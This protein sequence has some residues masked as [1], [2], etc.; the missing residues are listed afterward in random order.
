MN[1]QKVLNE[2]SN[3]HL[4][5]ITFPS[6]AATEV[7][8]PVLIEAG[9]RKILVDCGYPG[10]APL[11]EEALVQA[12]TNLNEVTDI[13]ITHH[14]LD[15]VGALYEIVQAHPRIQV[16]AS[17][18]ESLFVNGSQKAPRLLQAEALLDRLPD[19]QKSWA[20]A[21]QA[22]LENI[23]PVAVQH[24]LNEHEACWNGVQTI[25]TPGH[26][27]GHISLFL[28]AQK[29]L[30]AG[31]AVV[32]V[33]GKLDI[34]NP[35]YTLDLRQAVESVR[36]IAGLGVDR[37]ICFHGGMVENPQPLLDALLQRYSFADKSIL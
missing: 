8:Y 21:F 32:Y 29:T 31:D 11:I 27:P 25:A 23:R 36:K 6:G 18:Q 30:V 9:A 12:G 13:L 35:E 15:H 7:I 20:L 24:L 5:P 37:L 17:A 16:H 2:A 26:T 10:F 33:H 28:P 3:V 34:A 14:D 1:H 22:Q 4:L 19:D